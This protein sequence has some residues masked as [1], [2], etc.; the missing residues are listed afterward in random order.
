MSATVEIAGERATI[1][2]WEWTGSRAE[3]VGLLNGMLSTTGPGG[4]DPAPD[5]HEAE[6]VVGVLGGEVV[7]FVVPEVVEGVVY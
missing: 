3:L 1:D 6:R 4:D 2:G 7:E 5:Y